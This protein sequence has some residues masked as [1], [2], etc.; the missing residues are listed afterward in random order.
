MGVPWALGGGLGII[1]GPRAAPK[2]PQSQKSDEKFARPPF[3]PQSLGS[4]KSSIFNIFTIF[5]DLFSGCFSEACF[6]G[7]RPPIL[8]DSGIIF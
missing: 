7:L 3:V 1:L 4:P 2:A 6:G 5:V 8:E